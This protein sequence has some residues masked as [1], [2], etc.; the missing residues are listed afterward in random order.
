[1]G[2]RYIPGLGIFKK[3]YFLPIPDPNEQPVTRVPEQDEDDYVPLLIDGIDN[4]KVDWHLDYD[5]VRELVGDVVDD[6]QEFEEHPET[7]ASVAYTDGE[8][9]AQQQE[10][11]CV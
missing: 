2:S 1:M 3:F 7:E 6:M 11:V 8:Q 4:N 10:Q 9:D 5:K